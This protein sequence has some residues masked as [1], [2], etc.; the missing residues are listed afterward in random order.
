MNKAKRIR[1]VR[2]GWKIGDAQEFLGLLKEEARF[3]AKIFAISGRS[4]MSQ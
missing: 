3:L 4:H 1:L 2:K